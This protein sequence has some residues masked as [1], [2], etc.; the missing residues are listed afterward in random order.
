MKT[1]IKNFYEVI[2]MK[3]KNITTMVL[4]SI[5]IFIYMVFFMNGGCEVI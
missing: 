3:K 5:A 2:V 1:R 4:V